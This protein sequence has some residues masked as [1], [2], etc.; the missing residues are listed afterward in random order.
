[1]LNGTVREVHRL[2]DSGESVPGIAERLGLTVNQVHGYLGAWKSAQAATDREAERTRSLIETLRAPSGPKVDTPRVLNALDH[3]RLRLRESHAF[4]SGYAIAMREK[5]DNERAE[6]AKELSQMNFDAANDV[7][8]AAEHVREVV[9]T[10][11]SEEA[12]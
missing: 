3:A 9:Y 2:K 7:K 10:H 4:W 5:G 12:E 11:K 1:M 8:T 6:A